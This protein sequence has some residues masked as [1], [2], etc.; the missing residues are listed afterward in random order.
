MTVNGEAEFWQL[1]RRTVVLAYDWLMVN[2]PG[3]PG[4]AVPP[5]RMAGPAAKLR[6]LQ[7]DGAA[8]R[9]GGPRVRVA[10]QVGSLSR[11]EGRV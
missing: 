6:Q 1:V 2:L 5:A 4:P 3:A 9:G 11:Q 8:G 7:V 10:P